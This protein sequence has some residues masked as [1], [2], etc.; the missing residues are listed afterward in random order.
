MKSLLGFAVAVCV[1][2]VI[3]RLLTDRPIV[4]VT[5]NPKVK[6]SVEN[7]YMRDKGGL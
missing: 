2:V 3:D 6:V 7:A 1:G 4:E 5:F